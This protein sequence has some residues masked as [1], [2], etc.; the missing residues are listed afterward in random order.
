MH[1]LHLWCRCYT[2]WV[3]QAD[4]VHQLEVLTPI[5]KLLHRMRRLTE[6]QNHFSLDSLIPSVIL[7]LKSLP[8]GLEFED[9]QARWNICSREQPHASFCLSLSSFVGTISFSSIARTV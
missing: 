1:F 4:H 5:R 7:E 2:F 8:R 6:I 9:L 3:L